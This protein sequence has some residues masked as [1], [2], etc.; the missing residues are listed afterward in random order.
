ML[1]G[2]NDQDIPKA[3]LKHYR[4]VSNFNPKVLI[5]RR[6]ISTHSVNQN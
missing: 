2:I 1:E 5:E 4:N 6:E 3:F